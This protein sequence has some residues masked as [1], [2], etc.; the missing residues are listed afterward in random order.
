[1]PSAAD[2]AD[3]LIPEG[4]L[5]CGMGVLC[6]QASP[7]HLATTLQALRPGDVYGLQNADGG[8]HVHVAFLKLFYF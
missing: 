5:A 8:L 2:F 1:M 4:V 3:S 6:P 7:G